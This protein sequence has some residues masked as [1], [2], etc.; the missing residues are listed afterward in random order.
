MTEGEGQSAAIDD[1]AATGDAA[2]AREFAASRRYTQPAL[3]KTVTTFLRNEIR[4]D[5]NSENL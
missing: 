3:A 4:T 2:V 5:R 1:A